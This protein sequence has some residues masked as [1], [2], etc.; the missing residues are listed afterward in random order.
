MGIAEPGALEGGVGSS[1]FQSDAA[2]QPALAAD[3][4]IQQRMLEGSNVRSILEM[5]NMITVQR[6][7]QSASRFLEGEHE[8]MRRAVN[9]IIPSS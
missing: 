2:P 4:K 1:G 3:F 9:Y 6:S 8:R 5:T 7:Y